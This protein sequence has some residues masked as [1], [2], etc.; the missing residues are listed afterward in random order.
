MRAENLSPMDHALFDPTS[1][2][3]R[4]NHIL[5]HPLYTGAVIMSCFIAPITR[6][7]EQQIRLESYLKEI[8]VMDT[9][10]F[11]PG[12]DF[13]CFFGEYDKPLHPSMQ[14]N[15][16]AARV[17]HESILTW[18]S[19]H[20]SPSKVHRP[21]LSS[22]LLPSFTRFDMD[23]YVSHLIDDPGV[24][25]QGTLEYLHVKYG[26]EFE[27]PCEIKQRWYTN[28]LAPRTY[29]VTGATLYNSTK[30]TRDLWT[31]LCDSLVVTHRRNRVNPNRIRI[32]GIQRVLFYDLSSFTSNC[33]VQREFLN[34]LSLHVDGLPFTV[35]DYRHGR[36][37][38]NFADVVRD[39]CN[40]NIQPQYATGSYSYV[41]THGVAGF[42]GVVGNIATCNFVHGAFLLQLA[43]STSGCGCAGDDAVLATVEDEDTIW[44]CVSL[45]GVLAKEKVF[46]TD[47]PDCVY[48][49]RRVWVDVPFCRL[50]SATYVQLPSFLFFMK[51]EETRRYREHSATRAE[52]KS[53]ACHSIL[54]LFRSSIPFFDDPVVMMDITQ[55]ARDYYRLLHIPLL[56]N[57]PQFSRFQRADY[58]RIFVPSVSY[59]G[60][61]NY[62][63]GTIIE[64]YPGYC[65]VDVRPTISWAS[66]VVLHKD[67]VLKLIRTPDISQLVKM[68]FLEPVRTGEVMLE[69]PDGIDRLIED[70]T[71]RVRSEVGLFRVLQSLD[72]VPHPP[73]L[74]G[75]YDSDHAIAALFDDYDPVTYVSAFP[76][77]SA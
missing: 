65:F 52:L 64:T 19:A 8:A 63:E 72:D 62:V 17:V 9:D 31:D 6:E 5:S 74:L 16:G 29:Y 24:A 55:F 46:S 44:L 73:E 61:A 7:E 28:G 35:Q 3:E 48:L 57:V 54:A 75:E 4:I 37:E 71:G 45:V 20:S 33:A 70:Y 42:L 60:L 43:T 38:A 22:K 11:L 15:P 12:F 25:T 47:D 1:I 27:G 59:L 40:A 2:Y 50:A 39:Y 41:G 10:P 77:N 34:A 32:E 56:G 53:L 23:A 58:S 66:P 68:G 49:K 21:A 18:I 51:P 14:P 67:G 69:G 30:F 26:M 76:D 36:Y 13:Q